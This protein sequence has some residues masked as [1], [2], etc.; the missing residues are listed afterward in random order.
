MHPV[1]L[2]S[3]L[4]ASPVLAA[5]SLTV[6]ATAA[7]RDGT[8]VLDR[9]GFERPGRLQILLGE[10]HLTA[11][12]GS[13]LRALRLRRDGSRLDLRSGAVHVTITG[14]VTTGL[15]PERPSATFAQNLGGAPTVLFAGFVTLPA[16]PRLPNRDA[17]AW[18]A[19]DCVSLPFQTPLA[20]SG[21]TL[22]LQLDIVPLAGNATTWWPIDAERS[23]SSGQAVTRGQACGAV[24]ADR[25]AS[26]DVRSL[27]VGSAATLATLAPP[28]S[29]AVLVL[30][31]S[32]VGPIDLAFLG[33]P[34]CTLDVSPDMAVGT[35]ASPA[36][37][38]GRPG[39]AHLV[40]PLPHE[41]HLAG[42][43]F[44]AQWLLVDGS[45][46][47]TT[48]AL[49]LTVAAVSPALGASIVA[50]ASATSS[51]PAAG[52]VDASIVPVL[53]LDYRP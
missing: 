33:A 11:A 5:Q 49:D 16:A 24:A 52:Q 7:S 28:N 17:A 13:S 40:L 1:L 15:D 26:V 35:T 30:G 32:P 34:G 42:A 51:L 12:I 19:P 31:A 8:G 39:A 36:I 48:N 4:V 50:A 46:L 44:H 38:S 18:Q 29:L 21:G 3:I 9:V 14:S 47:T 37:V 23:G 43:T 20:Y 45:Q 10:P 53:Q 22:C 2:S 6:P 27:R 41:T 25:P